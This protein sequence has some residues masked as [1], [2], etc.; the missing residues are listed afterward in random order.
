MI[1]VVL[2]RL[3]KL[4]GQAYENALS[5]GADAER[6]YTFGGSA[7][8]TLALQVANHLAKN[9]TTRHQVKGVAALVPVTLHYDY[10]PV[11]YR[12]M[13]TSYEENATNVPVIDKQSIATFF[14]HAAV[15]AKDPETFVA[16]DISNHENYPPT[17]IVTC[18][19]DPLRDDGVV[20]ECALKKAGVP[21]KRDHWAGLP[22]YF[23]MFPRIPE[24]EEFAN[25]LLLGLDWLF[26]QEG[27]S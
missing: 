12:P 4:A 6:F 10:V 8:G 3:T 18:E 27:T 23:W 14:Q 21:T 24:T 15:D 5:L 13:F 17:H 26:E 19:M 1:P 2:E 11:E 7:G 16:L 22:H 25:R 9:P 20:M